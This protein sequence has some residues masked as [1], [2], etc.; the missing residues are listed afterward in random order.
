M[1]QSGIAVVI[2]FVAIAGM[3][4]LAKGSPD[5][6]ALG[7]NQIY[8]C[9]LLP[10][11]P[12]ELAEM[13][14]FAVTITGP[15]PDRWG[16]RS[17]N[18][19][20]W[21]TPIRNQGRCGSCWAFGSLAAVEAIFNIKENSPRDLNLSEQYLLSC[22]PGSCRG[23][24]MRST[25]D[26]IVEHGVIPESCF[27]YSAN[28]RIPCTDKCPDW[29][30]KILEVS[31]W[32][33][34]S[35]DKTSIKNAL[36]RY[37]PLPTAID[38]YRDF[39]Y[40]SRGVY[41]H[42]WGDLVGYHLV[43]I[44]GYND[45]DEC[46]I[47]KNSWGTGWGEDGWFRIGYG[48]CGIERSTAWLDVETFFRM[49]NVRAKNVSFVVK[50]ENIAFRE[51]GYLTIENIRVTPPDN[52]AIENIGV[53]KIERIEPIRI[54]SE[55]FITIENIEIY[56]AWVEVP[57]TLKAIPAIKV[58][59]PARIRFDTDI[60]EITIGVV[61]DVEDVEITFQE[62]IEKPN[63]IAPSPEGH[64][65]RYF[66]L[67]TDIENSID[68]VRFEFRVE[69]SWIV[70]RNIDELSVTLTRFSD[71]TWEPLLME[72]TDENQVY[73]Y[74]SAESPG[75]SVFAIT[76]KEEMP[77][78]EVSWALISG[79]VVIIAIIGIVVLFKRRHRGFTRSAI[80]KSY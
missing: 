40:Y 25:F 64:V 9:G 77:P 1:G 27:P 20:D 36:I 19:K 62:A 63:D 33:W 60:T 26:W 55:N 61:R 22:S 13:E 50:V 51:P 74:Y 71:G 73:V 76:G 24:Y 32:H 8:P 14:A 78:S 35:P 69:R 66:N 42:E 49:I 3:A 53:L 67:T 41:R 68:F 12:E 7:E 17:E 31:D 16:W 75:F 10:P 59:A 29:E 56:P 57:M 52:V 39:F 11:S 47:C 4:A 6:N 21:T 45:A 46:W 15:T 43:A 28:D 79:L 38:V 70:D 65:Y 58:E 72:K 54:D 37:G 23:W 48:E 18:G 30:N 80:I 44:V 34:V 5:E 2:L